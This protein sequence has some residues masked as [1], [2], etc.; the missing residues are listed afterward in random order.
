MLA[1]TL[2]TLRELILDGVG[3]DIPKEER[4]EFFRK[5]FPKLEEEELQDFASIDPQ[6][7]RIYRN[8]IF[9]GEKKLLENLLPRTSKFLSDSLRESETPQEKPFSLRSLVMDIHELRPWKSFRTKDFLENFCS[10]LECEGKEKLPHCPAWL[11]ALARLEQARYEIRKAP[12]DGAIPFPT[13]SLQSLS[14]E[15]LLKKECSLHSP[16]RLLELPSDILR[17]W[18]ELA[19]ENLPQ[20]ASS[21]LGFFLVFRTDDLQVQVEALSNPMA[22]FLREKANGQEF[23]LGELAETLVR[24]REGSEES[25]FL[26]FLDQTIPLL[27]LGFLHFRP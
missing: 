7:L 5:R 18:K 26:Y 4:L 3:L 12:G 19:S 1:Q 14:V 27:Q 13:E 20:E 10:F 11:P 15:Q 2:S 23:S 9:E 22:I 24:D 21:E 8:S 16:H 6:K 25:R 17:L